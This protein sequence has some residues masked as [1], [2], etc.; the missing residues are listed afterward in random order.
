MSVFAPDRIPSEDHWA[1]NTTVRCQHRCIYCFEGDRR[2]LRDVPAEEIRR[3]LDKASQEVPRVIFMGA[4]PTL[5]PDLADL[6][7]HANS[8]GLET[9]IST[10][11]L[12]LADAAYLQELV[13]AG[14]RNI[15]MSFPYA[16]AE[17]YALMTGARPKG[18]ERL[19]TALDNMDQLSAKDSRIHGINVNV[20]VSQY[21]IDQL[22]QVLSHV[23]SRLARSSYMFTFKRVLRPLTMAVEQ[24]QD[25]VYVPCSMLRSTFAAITKSL[26]ASATFVF[27]GFPL[28]VVPRPVALDADLGYWLKENVVMDNF[29]HQAAIEP[30]YPEQRLR[31]VHAYE[32]LCDLCHLNT[33]CLQRGLFEIAV[34]QEQFCPVPFLEQIPEELRAW[35][36]GFSRGKAALELSDAQT[37]R[38]GS[39]ASVLQQLLLTMSK[40]APHCTV[41]PL[42][43][44]TLEIAVRGQRHRVQVRPAASQPPAQW[45]AG[46]WGIDEVDSP[47]PE[48]FRHLLEP[49]LGVLRSMPSC[50]PSDRIPVAQTS[51]SA[52]KMQSSDE[53]NRESQGQLATGPQWRSVLAEVFVPLLEDALKRECNP[54]EDFC[55][56]ATAENTVIIRA[57]GCN[58]PIGVVPRSGPKSAGFLCGSVRVDVPEHVLDHPQM[59][60]WL[61]VAL[62]L[63]VS[64]SN[65]GRWPCTRYD[66]A[67]G[68]LAE[69]WGVFGK[70]LLPRTGPRGSLWR[71]TVSDKDLRL[72]FTTPEGIP[73][74]I[75]I[76]PHDKVPSPFAS[77]GS[78]AIRCRVSER[79]IAPAVLRIVEQYARLLRA[80]RNPLRLLR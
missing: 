42:T 1:I 74:E 69:A 5:N 63:C 28:C 71:G 17:T 31:L 48:C 77:N 50:A 37:S 57:G 36:E 66:A 44:G 34:A 80:S 65:A 55:I 19:L 38:T 47:A 59:K 3:L 4:E 79:S 7:R 60:A 8:K 78:L 72:C 21:N 35:L 9:G 22:E 33:I 6:I 18:F 52:L 51:R 15:E 75:G 45:Q 24:F 43:T 25:H 46:D 68:F 27:R 73:F 14:L 67:P 23:V 54:S 40:K 49:L 30:M 64:L 32:W 12:R 41:K 56:M 29:Q 53:I 10:N 58:L 70:A 13:D 11:A 16:N 62:H 76:L 20:V 61:S 26:S 2:G 39:Y